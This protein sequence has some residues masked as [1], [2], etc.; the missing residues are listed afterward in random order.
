MVSSVRGCRDA[1]ATGRYT[2]AIT[3]VGDGDGTLEG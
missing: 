2:V 3:I 1:S